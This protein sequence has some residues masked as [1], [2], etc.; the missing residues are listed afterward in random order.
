MTVVEKLAPVSW[1]E[2]SEASLAE[3]VATRDELEQT[4]NRKKREL[5]AGMEQRYRDDPTATGLPSP[6]TTLGQLQ[7][8]ID[9]DERRYQSLCREINRRS[10][11]VEFARAERL[12]AE[13]A[14][15]A[16]VAL[17]ELRLSDERLRAILIPALEAAGNEWHTYLKALQRV[18]RLESA[19][20][21]FECFKHLER[22]VSDLLPESAEVYVSR[23]DAKTDPRRGRTNMGLNSSFNRFPGGA[24]EGFELAE[25]FGG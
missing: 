22:L 10:A 25:G 6:T 16:R 14:E 2:Q 20:V 11:Q 17:D 4:I 9:S 1:L 19:Q 8:S 24:P 12:R 5:E 7:K 18:D 21:E 23:L 13:Q 15:E 3:D